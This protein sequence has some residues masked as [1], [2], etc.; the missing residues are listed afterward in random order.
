MITDIVE[1]NNF[2]VLIEQSDE[3]KTIVEK[4][5]LDDKAIGFSDDKVIGFSFY[6]SGDVEISIKGKNTTKTIQNST[7][8]VTSFFGNNRVRFEH[9]I[10]HKKPL[11]CVSIFSTFKNLYKLPKQEIE[12]FNKYLYQLV[13]PGGDFVEGPRFYM[14]PDMQQA[15]SKIF[16]TTYKGVTRMLFLKSQITELLAHFFALIAQPV[17]HTINDRDTDKL[18]QAKEIIINQIVAPPSLNELS[19]MIGLNNY[20]LKKNF[21]ELFGVPVFKYLQHERLNKAHK[22][23]NNS[24]KSI[25]EV[26]WIVGYESLSSFS[27]A[28]LKKFGIRPSDIKK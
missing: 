9:K 22:L 2:I 27:N 1:I 3:E 19:K 13:N 20:K 15:V 18:Y 7:G 28:F 11:R 23:L 12:I 10:S 21:K 8:M 4:C 24:D 25:Q 6:G 5:D 17:T 14:T 26:A 16:N